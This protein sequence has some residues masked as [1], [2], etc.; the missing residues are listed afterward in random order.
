V[1]SADGKQFAICNW[2]KAVFQA[3]AQGTTCSGGKIAKRYDLASTLR[4]VYA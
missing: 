1:C 4:T 3:V 2:G